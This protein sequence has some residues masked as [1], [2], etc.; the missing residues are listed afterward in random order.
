MPHLI[1]EYAVSLADEVNIQD[2]VEAVFEGA[3]ASGLFNPK[4]IKARAHACDDYWIGGTKQAFVHVEIKLLPG[5]DEE[6]KKDLSQRVY[7]KVSAHVKK[8]VAISVELNDLDAKC[9]TK[10][11]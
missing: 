4:A 3:V 1:V 6:Q 9:Y 2:L 5:R 11:S 10:R 8:D 7:E